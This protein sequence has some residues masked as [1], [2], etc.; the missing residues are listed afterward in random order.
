VLGFRNQCSVGE[1]LTR[2]KQSIDASEQELISCSRAGNCGGGWWAF[3][4]DVTPGAESSSVLAYQASDLPCPKTIRTDYQAVTW[5]YVS[6]QS[7]VP[8]RS[9]VKAALC[10]HGPLAVGMYVDPA[11]QTAMA[12]H[13]EGDYVFQT[14]ATG[15]I[16]HGVELVG[17]DDQ[18]QAWLIKNSWGDGQGAKG[19]MWI[20]Y[21]SS[22]LGEGAA[23]AEVQPATVVPGL[24]STVKDTIRQSTINSILSVK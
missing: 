6:A 10:Q 17:W 2:R 21:G 3:D 11:F 23:W 24:V 4:F 15:K 16:N 7:A 22:S 5:G 20:H 9:D 19:F 12:T 14:Q 8:K 13:H 18:K 1:R